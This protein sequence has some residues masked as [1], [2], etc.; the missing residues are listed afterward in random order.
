MAETLFL[1]APGA[2][3]ASSHPWMKRWARSLRRIGRVATVD[4][5][6]MVEGRK[7]PDRLGVLIAAHRAALESARTIHRGPIVLIGKSMGSRVGCHVALEEKVHAIVC[8][9]YPLCAMGDPTKLRDEVL[10]K[11]KTPILFVQGT[12]DSL[13]PLDLLE[14]VRKRMK[15]VNRL[16]VVHDGDHSLLVAKRTLKAR[17]ETQG[18]VEADLIERIEAF[19]G[20]P[21]TKLVTR[22]RLLR[23]AHKEAARS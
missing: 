17:S 19:V 22:S 10:I 2:G 7:R 20:N 14:P 23:R 21:L 15:A 9:G 18:D 1:F 3:A 13:C 11:L 16:E 4:Y 12:R 6:Y 8:L 5:P